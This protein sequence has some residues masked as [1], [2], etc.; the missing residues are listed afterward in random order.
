MQSQSDKERLCR[1]GKIQALKKLKQ[2]EAEYGKERFYWV[3]VVE[4]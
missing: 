2:E 4:Y 3:W 1:G